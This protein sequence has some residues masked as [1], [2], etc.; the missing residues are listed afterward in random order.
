M[1]SS[2][3]FLQERLLVVV[4]YLGSRYRC[5]AYQNEREEATLPSVPWIQMWPLLFQIDAGDRM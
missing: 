3:L 1:R 4:G 5:S 2:G